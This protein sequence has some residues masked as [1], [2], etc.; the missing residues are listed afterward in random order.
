MT[1]LYNKASSLQ[2]RSLIDTRTGGAFRIYKYEDYNCVDELKQLL[3]IL[4]INYVV[5]E[6]KDCKLSTKDIDTKE[7]LAHIEWVIKIGIQNSI[8]L[9]FVKKEWEQLLSTYEG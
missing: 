9:D 8:E 2:I 3:K 1:D 7:L 6:E 5:D 4:N